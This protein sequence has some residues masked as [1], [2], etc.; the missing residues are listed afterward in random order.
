M[1][2]LK[3]WEWMLEGRLL[4]MKLSGD[5]KRVLIICVLGF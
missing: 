5:K 2:L 3:N 4:L 1:A